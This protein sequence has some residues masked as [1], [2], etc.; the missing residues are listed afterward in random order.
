MNFVNID[1]CIIDICNEGVFRPHDCTLL[2]RDSRCNEED[3]KYNN[4]RQACDCCHLPPQMIDIPLVCCIYR[5]ITMSDE[6]HVYK[7]TRY[8]K[9]VL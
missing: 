5:N 4:R 7:S 9:P 1:D 3:L 2:Q 6:M 8:R